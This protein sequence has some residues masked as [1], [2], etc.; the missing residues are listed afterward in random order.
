MEVKFIAVLG[1]ASLQAV[2]GTITRLLGIWLSCV[3][4]GPVC[5]WGV[6]PLYGRSTSTE[7]SLPRKAWDDSLSYLCM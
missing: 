7:V 6:P 2:L 1:I 5:V 4:V 3:W